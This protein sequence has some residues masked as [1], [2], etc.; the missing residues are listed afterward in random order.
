MSDIWASYYLQAKGFAV[1]YGKASVF[2][3]RNIH[4]PVHDMRQEYLGYENNLRIVEELPKSPDAL[5]AYL[6]ERAVRAFEL[7]KK[8]FQDER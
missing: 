8:H 7:Y 6:P 3:D 5:F 1:V 4:D 2:Q